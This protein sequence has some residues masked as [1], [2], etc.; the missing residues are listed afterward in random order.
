V[1]T[2]STITEFIFPQHER[3][4]GTLQKFEKEQHPQNS[5]YYDTEFFSLCFPHTRSGAHVGLYITLCFA[6]FH[7][8]CQRTFFRL[9]P[10]VDFILN[11]IKYSNH[12]EEEI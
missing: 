3:N 1:V 5:G 9:Y 4:T 10:S 11:I 2:D 7:L 8:T 6:F 12:R